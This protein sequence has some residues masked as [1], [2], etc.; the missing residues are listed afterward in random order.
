MGIFSYKDLTE[1]ES[2][3]LFSDALALTMYS[4]HGFDDG[5]ASGYQ[6]SGL[7]LGLPLTMI[8]TIFGSSSSQGLVP[9]VPWNTD[10]EKEA[11][12]AIEAA[13]WKPISSEVL[14]YGGTVDVRGTY[15]GEQ[16]GFQTAQMDVM[17]K[18]NA[19]GELTSIG[20][21]IRGTT[22]PRESFL[23]D[24]LGDVVNDLKMFADP[25]GYAKQY[26]KNAFDV[27]LGDVAKYALSKG[28]TGEDIVVTGHSLGGMATNSLAA[29]SEDEWNGF[30]SN[31][32]YISYASPTIYDGLDKVLNVG[33]EN[34]PVLR[35]AAG[36]LSDFLGV[37]D[38]PKES[39]T[40][41]IVSFNDQYASALWQVAPFSLL[42][43]SSLTAH[44]PSFYGDGLERITQSEFYDLTSRDSTII[45]AQLSE[46]TK[47]NT[48]VTDLNYNAQPHV[49]PTLILG[50]EGRD[51]IKGGGGVDYL[52][53]RGGD[54]IFRDA[55]GYNLISGGE[56]RDTFDLQKSLSSFKVA[57]DGAGNLY[58]KDTAGAINIASSIEVLKTKESYLLLFS[59]ERSYD[60]TQEGLK[61]SGGITGYE[62]SLHGDVADNK[63]VATTQ[64]EW[65]FGHDGNDTLI[66]G[67][68]TNIVG[69]EGNDL[70]QSGG[71]FNTLLFTKDFG[72]DTVSGFSSTDKLVFMGVQAYEPNDNW[73]QHAVDVD[74]G[75]K[76]V[77][78]DDSV[79]LVGVN[80]GDL[81]AS[82]VVIA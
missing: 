9:G 69:G 81:S 8:E 64:N 68:A 26:M 12:E 46:P 28:L 19:A 52:E 62:K 77:F 20:L 61:Y 33:Y 71:N 47:V 66:G 50:S 10:S 45:V 18:Y 21:A 73:T 72:H 35:L 53:G 34:D 56:G 7:S 6:K 24:T 54:D 78:G 3:A 36:S 57:N 11:L 74:E 4:Y 25:D 60:V 51:L 14:G 16:P 42:N 59:Q 43:P 22:G 63:L 17:G 75:V 80:I 58:I 39:A 30:Y 70:I 40:N 37:H 49:G 41:N 44:L 1:T 79:T 55:G 67:R 23:T 65:L 2:A 15:Y 27:L 5:F 82:Q 38:S 48:W 29:L 76:L 32:N 31:S 13:G